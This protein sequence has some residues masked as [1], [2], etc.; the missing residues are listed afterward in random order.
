MLEV[1]VAKADVTGFKV[2]VGMM[3]YGMAANTV[4]DRGTGLN[5][6]AFVFKDIATSRKFVFVNAEICF[7]TI[8]IKRGVLKRLQRFHSEL[9]Y[10]NENVLLCAQHTHSG[11][12]GYSHFGFY[13][14]SIPGFVPEVYQAIVDGIVEAIVKADQST[15]SASLYY[16]EGEFDPDIEV[17]FNRS[18]K[19]YN[20]NPEVEPLPKEHWHLAIDRV[21]RL[22]R[23]EGTEGTPIGSINWFPVHCTTLSNDNHSINFDNKGYAAKY[24]E[25][26]VSVAS[27]NPDFTAVFAQGTAGDVSPNYVWDKKKK[28]T[29]GKFENDVESAQY[30]GKLQF[31]KATEIFD[32]AL[33]GLKVEGEIDYALMYANFANVTPDPEFTGGDPDA[34]TSPACHGVT[35]LKGTVEGP[36]MKEIEGYFVNTLTQIVKAAEYTASLFMSKHKKEKLFR[37]YRSQGSKH[38]LIEAGER[39]ILGTKNV[40]KLLVPSWADPTIRTM[41]MHHKNGSLGHKPWTPQTLPLQI[42]IIGPLA[43]VAIPGEITTI[44]GKRLRKT[45]LDVL[46]ERGVTKILLTPY[47]NCYSGYITTREEYDVQCYEGGHTVYG[48]WTLAAFQTKFKQLAQEMLKRPEDRDIELTEP[49]TFSEE[50]LK[51]RSF[52]EA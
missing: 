45:I 33:N 3:G 38:I 11:P 43:L 15:K 51:K 28:W 37:K 21:M 13:N 14:F 31:D 39:K 50:E 12:G 40:K 20:K 6:R 24:L 18:L 49:V 29:R 41:K 34:I 35:F 36:G 7:I 8:S 42:V 46:K 22:V 4:E 26:A 25:E 48:Q 30:N 19:A 10:T 47:S 17:A 27:N 5:A 23:I 52:S 1:G 32:R 16:D 9:G 2:G 44:A